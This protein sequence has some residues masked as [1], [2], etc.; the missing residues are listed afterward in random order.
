MTNFSAIT[1]YYVW[2]GEGFNTSAKRSLPSLSLMSQDH[3]SESTNNTSKLEIQVTAQKQFMEEMQMNHQL[4]NQSGEFINLSV[5][6]WILRNYFKWRG[7]SGRFELHTLLIS[8]PSTPPL[9]WTFRGLI[10]HVKKK[11][12]AFYL[13]IFIWSKQKFATP[14][15]LTP[16]K[17]EK[18]RVASS[19][20]H[21]TNHVFHH[22][23]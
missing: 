16:S 2:S 13:Y 20:I 14:P 11:K 4:Q 1:F 9:P 18:S 7:L 10:P 22:F 12:N 8:S 6:T 15:H 17:K 21:H 5:F 23:I 3:V 19:K